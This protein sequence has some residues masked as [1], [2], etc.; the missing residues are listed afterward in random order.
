MTG[1][2]MSKAFVKETD[3]KFTADPLP[4][5]PVPAGPNLVTPEGLTQINNTIARLQ[6]EQDAARR[7]EDDAEI[8]KL[9]REL[10][11]WTAR[12]T[13][14]QLAPPSRSHGVVVFGST[15]TIRRKDGRDQTYRIVGTDEADPAQGT[16]SHTSPLARAL[17]DK[18]VGDTSRIANADDEIVSIR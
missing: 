5:R 3:Q 14:A 6:G 8:A 2:D 9:A 18:S 11:Y 15:V 10:R 1:T 17:L 13:T 7:T 12:Q 16:L 4:D